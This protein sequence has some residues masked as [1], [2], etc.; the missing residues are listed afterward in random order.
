M[1]LMF[2]PFKPYRL[3]SWSLDSEKPLE[4]SNKFKG[5]DSY[6]VYYSYLGEPKSWN[7]YLDIEVPGN[8]KNE[9]I[10]DFSVNGH[11]LHGKNKSSKDM[12]KIVAKFPN[13]TAVSYWIA[14]IRSYKI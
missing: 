1:N 6:F 4:G 10:M 11:F 2:S 12:D 8:Y 5:R 14:T 3:L 7:F 13:W 9:T